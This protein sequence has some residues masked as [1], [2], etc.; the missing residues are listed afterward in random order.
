MRREEE[1]GEEEEDEEDEGE[2][3]E[4]EEG[5][6]RRKKREIRGGGEIECS[7]P[8]ASRRPVIVWRRRVAFMEAVSPCP[9]IDHTSTV[10]D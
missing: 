5:R 7:H 3:E 1:E 8:G 4:D 2:E 9:V 10:L 6:R